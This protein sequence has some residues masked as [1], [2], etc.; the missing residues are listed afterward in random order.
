MTDSQLSLSSAI[1][2]ANASLRLSA[3]FYLPG[4]RLASVEPLFDRPTLLPWRRHRIQASRFLGQFFVWWT[5]SA[6]VLMG[7]SAGRK[8]GI[9][10]KIAD[11]TWSGFHTGSW[12]KISPNRF[13]WHLHYREVLNSYDRL[14]SCPIPIFYWNLNYWA[15]L[16]KSCRNLWALPLWEERISTR[17][18]PVSNHTFLT[19]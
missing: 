19:S 3:V 7:H 14:E 9:K 10:E 6:L 8:R 12:K 11:S 13:S 2:F 16:L 15:K 4:R 1:L 17:E 18:R 5:L